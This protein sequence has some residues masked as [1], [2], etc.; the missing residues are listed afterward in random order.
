[1]SFLTSNKIS[2]RLLIFQRDQ[3]RIKEIV[4]VLFDL[5]LNF[6]TLIELSEGPKQD[7]RDR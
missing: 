1:M 3:S 4:D 5:E 6:S 7:Q 2:R